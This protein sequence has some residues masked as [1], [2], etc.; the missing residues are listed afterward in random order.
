[1]GVVNSK[2]AFIQKQC[3]SYSNVSAEGLMYG[4]ANIMTMNPE[5]LGVLLER[6]GYEDKEEFAAEQQEASSVIRKAGL[7]LELIKNGSS[8]ILPFYKGS[9]NSHFYSGLLKMEA[10]IHFNVVVSYVIDNLDDEYRAAFQEGNTLDDIFAFQ[11]K[12]LKAAADSN[13]DITDEKENVTEDDIDDEPDSDDIDKVNESLEDV[14][15]EDG[16]ENGSETPKEQEKESL[17]TPQKQKKEPFENTEWNNS[18]A[19][20]THYL[21]RASLGRRQIESINSRIRFFAET[22]IG[23]DN[24]ETLNDLFHSLF[25][26]EGFEDLK[27][28][29][30]EYEDKDS[31]ENLAKYKAAGH[32]VMRN[33][34]QRVEHHKEKLIS[35]GD[36]LLYLS[37]KYANAYQQLTDRVV[38]QDYAVNEFVQSCFD[39]ELYKDDPTHP[40][41]VFLFAGPPGVGKT[42]LAQ[43]VADILGRPFKA[44][45]MAAYSVEKSDLALIG[46][47]TGFKNAGEGTLVSF[48]EDNPDAI[49]LFDEIEK[50]HPDIT[51]LFLSVLDGARLENKLLAT[52]TDFSKT[53]LIFTTNA[54]KSIYE[55]NKKNL[56]AT[57]TDVIIKEL[58]KEKSSDG[59]QPKFPPELCSRFASQHI[60]MFNHI[61]ISDMVGLVV[62]HMDETCKDIEE[63][64]QISIEYDKRLALL[65]LMHFGDMDVRVVTGQ[66]QQ[67]I[68]REVYELSRHLAEINGVKGIKK[69]RFSVDDERITD[70]A[71]RFFSAADSEDTLVAVVCDEGTRKKLENIH[72]EHIRFLFIESEEK[73]LECDP[74]DVTVFIV[75]P[76]YSMCKTN[77]NIL[78]LDDYDSVGLRIIKAL[79]RKNTNTPIFM[80][81]SGRKVSQTDKN[82]LYMRGVEDTICFD[83]RNTLEIIKGLVEEHLLQKKCSA[84]LNRRKVF[85]FESLQ[86]MPDADG[87][88]NIKFYDIVVKDAVNPE[89]QDLL[90]NIEERPD[91]VFD[92]VIGADNA[93]DELKDF[94]KYLE[95]PK[96]YMKHSLAVPKGI[97]LYGPP[98]TGK[99]MLAKALASETDATFISVSAAKLRNIGEESIER[100]FKVA[101]KYAPAIVFIDEADAI[102]HRRTGSSLS[103][104]DES[105]L[106]MFLT[107]MDGFELHNNEPVFVV[108]ATNF[109]VEA[110]DDHSERGLDPAF[111]RR[112]GNKILVDQP[113]KEEKMQFL[114]KR[115][116]SKEGAVLGNHVTEEGMKNVAERTPGETLA[117]IEN[118]LELS[119]RNAAR[120]GKK[121]DDELLDEAM[122]EY[123]YGEKRTRDEEQAYRTAVHEAAHAY[124]YSLS[125]KKP[126]YLTVIS[127]GNFGGYMQ[128]ED[129]ENKATTSKEECIWSIRTS[130]A[131]RAGEM[132]IFGDA[133]ALNTGASSD[134]RHASSLAM[135]MLTTY[136]MQ[137]GHLFSISRDDLILSDLMPVYVE[138]AEK[139]LRQEEEACV[140]LVEKGKDKIIAIAKA[141]LEKNH[142]NREEIAELLAD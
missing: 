49:I 83:G 117:I 112:F 123:Y 31:N 126:T 24:E 25:N 103:S 104:Y 53:I 66:A 116:K 9:D 47:E 87:T 96:E 71:K 125:G 133:A 11:Q 80:L 38:G 20:L 36:R 39:A 139:I 54:G 127:R 2:I 119:F 37:E 142:L 61:G 109:G 45:D 124:I 113:N 101:R 5:L 41:A 12:L 32:K 84:M 108:A 19:K 16:V 63:K 78:G 29:Y 82:T 52:N 69:I 88:V 40:K 22:L 10:P 105:L 56:S 27:Q 65:L 131:G 134:L 121:L 17:K 137:E 111:L 59:G 85:D 58:R 132:V 42:Y 43:G 44:F 70:K 76:Y 106:N 93:K 13:N 129:E 128:R 102:A 74:E 135:S 73:L 14:E 48:V 26:V 118:I 15:S 34:W 91:V 140:E 35:A 141:L 99:T 7:S 28:A 114:T 51:R 110:S 120:K 72:H 97:L 115:L 89:D 77:D 21:E 62:K 1:M 86:E 92:D 130:L 81:E 94:V 18:Q 33:L 55:G 57:P 75:D 4:I 46:V 138:K 23:T 60:V 90:I 95:N 68:R 100:L 30:S 50:A 8:L 3:K 98:G 6:G 67:F 107:Q 122:E 64:L 79:L 136:G